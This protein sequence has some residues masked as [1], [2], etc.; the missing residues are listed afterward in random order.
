MP[1]KAPFLPHFIVNVSFHDFCHEICYRILLGLTE[2][3]KT[4]EFTLNSIRQ[5]DANYSN[6]NLKI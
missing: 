3:K 6:F 1:K 5:N 4:K 2:Q